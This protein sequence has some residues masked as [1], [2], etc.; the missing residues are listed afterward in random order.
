MCRLEVAIKIVA[1]MSSEQ[2]AI[3]YEVPSVLRNQRSKVDSRR[4]MVSRCDM[5]KASL[6]CSDKSISFLKLFNF[7]YS[8]AIEFGSKRRSFLAEVK[9]FGHRLSPQCTTTNFSARVP[10]WHHWVAHQLSPL[11]E[12][13]SRRGK[14]GIECRRAFGYCMACGR[15]RRDLLPAESRNKPDQDKGWRTAV[16]RCMSLPLRKGAN[17]GRRPVI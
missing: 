4:I 16:E 17:C 11:D 10:E 1:I 12:Y 3:P 5:I 8:G 6:I 9:V 15:W 2:S 13:A 7:R 14:V